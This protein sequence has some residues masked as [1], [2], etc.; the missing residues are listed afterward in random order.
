M[1][2][3]TQPVVGVLNAASCT[4]VSLFGAIIL[5]GQFTRFRTDLLSSWNGYSLRLRLRAQRMWP[6][7]KTTAQLTHES[8]GFVLVGGLDGEYE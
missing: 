6:L 2:S 8:P 7:G 5:A 4:V 3:I 1:S